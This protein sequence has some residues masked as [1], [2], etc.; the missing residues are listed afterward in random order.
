M[1]KKIVLKRKTG[2]KKGDQQRVS[3][4]SKMPK[5]TRNKRGDLG[6]GNCVYAEPFGS[7]NGAAKFAFRFC[8]LEFAKRQQELLTIDPQMLNGASPPGFNEFV[9]AGRPLLH[10]H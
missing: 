2:K 4:R 9:T 6:A 8:R 10:F 3:R 5:G 7:W 1:M